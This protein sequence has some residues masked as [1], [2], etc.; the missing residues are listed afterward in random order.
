MLACYTKYRCTSVKFGEIGSRKGYIFVHHIDLIPTFLHVPV[1]TSESASSEEWE[2][3]RSQ[4]HSES[5][6]CLNT[7]LVSFQMSYSSEGIHVS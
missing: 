2:L 3:D 5:F 7:P 4:S 6:R 1:S